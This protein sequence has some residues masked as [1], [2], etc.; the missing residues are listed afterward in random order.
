MDYIHSSCFSKLV[1]KQNRIV[2][3][4]GG[5]W[6]S[7]FKARLIRRSLLPRLTLLEIAPSYMK[8]PTPLLILPPELLIR[9]LIRS[10]T[11]TP[12]PPI[13]LNSFTLTLLHTIPLPLLC[14]LC[15]VRLICAVRL[16]RLMCAVH[17]VRLLRLTRP[18]YITP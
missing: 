15:A 2:V 6:H 12:K 13:S 18:T 3:Y 4:K 16:V 10:L 7:S 8:A 17:F 14:M 11:P 1:R 5:S 9:S